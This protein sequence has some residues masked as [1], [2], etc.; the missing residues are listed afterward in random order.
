MTTTFTVDYEKPVDGE[1]EPDTK[2]FTGKTQAMNFAAEQYQ[3]VDYRVEDEAN[4]YIEID[5]G[6]VNAETGELVSLKKDKRRF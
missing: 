5:R 4:D 3:S 6:Y 1:F 2:E